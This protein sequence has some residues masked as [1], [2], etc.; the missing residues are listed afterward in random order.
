VSSSIL[1]TSKQTWVLQKTSFKV[2]H[3]GRRRERQRSVFLLVHEV[4]G[5]LRPTDPAEARSATSMSSIKVPSLL[6]VAFR[7]VNL[8]P[9]L[10]APALHGTF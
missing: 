8:L 7:T 1:D 2:T 3:H 4:A 6:M 9:T 5:V 10:T